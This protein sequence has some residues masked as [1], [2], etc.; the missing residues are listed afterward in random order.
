MPSN[1][2]SNGGG[3]SY[4]T[5]LL[6]SEDESASCTSQ[7]SFHHKPLLLICFHCCQQIYSFPLSY[8]LRRFISP[9]QSL[10]FSPSHESSTSGARQPA[11][12]PETGFKAISGASVSA[13]FSRI[14]DLRWGFGRVSDG[15][16]VMTNTFSVRSKRKV[17]VRRSQH[18]NRD[19]VPDS[20]D[21]DYGSEDEADSGGGCG[22]RR[23]N[24]CGGGVTDV[25][26]IKKMK[27]EI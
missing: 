14:V 19:V 6:S 18:R 3:L 21:K 4:P 2:G 27:W 22:R 23:W 5:V 20:F 17:R 10:R 12:L 7:K 13:E 24:C 1:H 11:G 8:S 15:V 9:S 25:D 26:F 16:R